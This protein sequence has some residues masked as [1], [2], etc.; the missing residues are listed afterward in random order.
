MPCFNPRPAWRSDLPNNNGKHEMRFQFRHDKSFELLPCGTCEGCRASQKRDWAV[1]IAHESTSWQRNCFVTLTYDEANCPEKINPVHPRNFIKRLRHHSDRP[2]R[3]YITGEY[4]EKTHRP[5]YHA[6]IF[7]EDFLGG[8]YEISE[9]LYGN[10]ILDGIWKKG[11]TA[12]SEFTFATAM[13][14]AGYTAKKINDPDTFSLQSRIPPLGKNWV[15]EHHDNIRRNKNVV[16]NGQEFPVP[17]VYFQWLE[18][19]EQYD[20]VK[21]D[22][23][24]QVKQK[25]LKTLKNRRINHIAQ[26]S[27]RNEKI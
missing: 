25:P 17:K 16:I 23:K 6:I 22:I 15:R 27:L 19:A 8:A 7:N 14:V 2:I 9:Q 3:Y 10:K 21:E 4:G 5:H 1:R 24:H 13:Y 18:G 11:S 26:Q 12:I 20:K